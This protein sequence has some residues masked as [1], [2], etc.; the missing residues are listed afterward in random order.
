MDD[1][2]ESWGQAELIFASYAKLLGKPLLELTSTDD[3]LEKM[4]F[5]DFAILSHGTQ[6]DSIFNF[7]NQFA[8]D[9]FELTWSDMRNLP[10]RYSAEAPN[11][12]ER[13][14]LLDRVTQYGFIDDY[15]GVRIS[16]TGKR[17]LIKQAVVWNLVDEYGVYRGQAAAFSQCEDLA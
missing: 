9:K 15:Q 5:A 13:K 7:A 14:A 17:F 2:K 12:E 4:Y 1:W 6:V 11:R 3:L 16:S 10:S 8:L